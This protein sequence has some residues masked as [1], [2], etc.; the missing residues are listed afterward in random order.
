M[1]FEMRNA[2]Q[3]ANIF[4]SEKKINKNMYAYRTRKFRTRYPEKHTYCFYLALENSTS[5]DSNEMLQSVAS[6]QGLH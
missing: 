6:H 4:F 3:K 1:H 2:F 5:A